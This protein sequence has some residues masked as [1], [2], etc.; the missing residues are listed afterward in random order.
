MIEHQ[1]NG[2][3]SKHKSSKSLAEGIKWILEDKN[4]VLKLKEATRKNAVEKYSL[5]IQAKQY[6]NLYENLL[7]KA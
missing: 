2:Y 7:S 6:M 4:R 5:E 3:L 1:T